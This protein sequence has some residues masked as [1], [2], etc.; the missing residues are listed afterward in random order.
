MSSAPQPCKMHYKCVIKCITLFGR[1]IYYYYIYVLF[2]MAL[3]AEKTF[4]GRI[5]LIFVQYTRRP[6]NI[7]PGIHVGST[8]YL[9][10]DTTRENLQNHKNIIIHNERNSSFLCFKVYN[11][12]QYLHTFQ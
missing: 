7:L 4:V 5:Y 6:K 10:S 3:G 1:A 9:C 8:D 2:V 12:E 11:N